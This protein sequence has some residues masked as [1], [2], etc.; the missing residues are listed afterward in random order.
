[1]SEPSTIQGG[2]AVDDRGSVR[3]VNDFNF[4][5]VKRFYQVQNHQAGFIRAWH[6]HLVEGKYAYV[7]R[8]SI[9]LGVV[10]LDEEDVY[11][12]DPESIIQMFTLSSEK[13]QVL[14]IPPGYA[15]GFKTLT[16]DAVVIFFSTISLDDSIE[17]GDDFRFDWDY[18]FDVWAEDYR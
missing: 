3:F 9:R 7:A 6:G 1:M 16:D 2:L 11:G 14:W 4:E 18:F 10:K 17:M 12:T 15:N 5:G 13:P 8:G